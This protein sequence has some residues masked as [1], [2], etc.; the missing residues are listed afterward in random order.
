[1]SSAIDHRFGLNVRPGSSGRPTWAHV[2]LQ[3]IVRQANGMLAVT[4]PCSSLEEM[5]T[6]IAQLKAELDDVL[7]QA[8]RAFASSGSP[9]SQVRTS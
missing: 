5:E 6:Q 1:M 4:P 3:S 9:T 2:F 8:R 7:R